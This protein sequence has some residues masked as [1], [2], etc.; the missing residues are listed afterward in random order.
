MDAQSLTI[1]NL[2]SA[3]PNWDSLGIFYITFAAVWTFL[4]VAGMIFCLYNQ[5]MPL[6]RVRNLPLSFAAITLLHMYWIMAQLVYPIGATMPA[7]AA[8]DVQYLVMGIVFPLGIALFHAANWRFLRVAQLQRK[9]LEP[10][11]KRKSRRHGLS[12]GRSLLARWHNLLLET[13]VSAFIGLAMFLQVSACLTMWAVCRK[14]HPGFG[15]PGTEITGSNIQEQLTNLGRG[16]EWWPTVLYQLVWMW[17][18]AP[19]LIWRAWG[20]NDT[21]G[22]RTQTIGSCL[23]GLHAVPM[24]LVALYVPA[25]AKVNMYL[26]PS[27][28]IHLN[29]FFIEIFTI[30]I[31]VRQVIK[32]WSLGKQVSDASEKDDYPWAEPTVY[33]LRPK[34]SSDALTAASEKFSFTDSIESFNQF[35]DIFGAHLLTMGALERFL[36]EHPLHLQTFSACRDFSGENI[37]F[38]RRVAEW[39]DTLPQQTGSLLEGQARIDAYNAALAIYLDLISPQDADFPLNLFSKQLLALQAVFEDAARAIRRGPRVDVV[40]PF[41]QRSLHSNAELSPSIEPTVD[42]LADIPQ[43]FN[44]EV[45]DSALVSIKRLVLDNTWPKFVVEMRSRSASSKCSSGRSV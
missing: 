11:Y 33:I 14:Y 17:L 4:V 40:L 2:P 6:L 42:S 38:L 32:I 15:A 43:G 18:V 27:Q 1:Y 9:L 44:S 16:W 30:F 41:D 45:F 22:W 35:D 7:V 26:G 29:T 31:P 36:G 34:Q 21:L 3:K 8:Y 24:F 39:K 37:M 23:S 5:R 10:E 20:I 28:W 25:F 19:Y 12:K 13:K